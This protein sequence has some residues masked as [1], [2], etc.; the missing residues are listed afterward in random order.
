MHCGTS[1]TPCC[2]PA[3]QDAVRLMSLASSYWTRHMGPLRADDL[4]DTAKL[5][6]LARA[7]IDPGRID[8]LWREGAALT[9]AEAVTIALRR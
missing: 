8:V 9:V 1:P 7:R 5:K 3:E 6:R 2:V 4:R